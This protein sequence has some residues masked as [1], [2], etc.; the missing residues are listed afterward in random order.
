MASL[1]KSG[2]WRAGALVL[3]LLVQGAGAATYVGVGIGAGN[4]GGPYPYGGWGGPYPYRGP[5]WGP[6]WGPGP[7]WGP[8]WDPWWDGPYFPPDPPVITPPVV[9]APTE[10]TIVPYLPQRFEAQVIGGTTYFIADGVY[11]K[12]V[13]E[14]YLV[15]SSPAGPGRG[16]SGAA[17]GAGRIIAYPKL[18]QRPPEQQRDREECEADARARMGRDGSGFRA[19]IEDCLRGRGYVVK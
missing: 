14:G 6:G 9:V 18:G 3:A 5:Y 2:R 8:Y 1:V 7:A 19:A 13:P 11:Y 12:A 16:A 10:G 4:Y 17:D 15:T